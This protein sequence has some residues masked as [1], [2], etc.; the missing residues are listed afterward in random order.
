V[1]ASR[2]GCTPPVAGNQGVHV[3]VDPD[4]QVDLLVL[5]LGDESDEM[6]ALLFDTINVLVEELVVQ[7]AQNEKWASLISPG[8]MESIERARKRLLKPSGDDT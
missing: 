2:S 7:K 3:T 1:S 8:S 6:I 4:K 5:V